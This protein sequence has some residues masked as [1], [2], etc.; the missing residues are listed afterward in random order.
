MGMKASF[1]ARSNGILV[2]LIETF[3]VELY[4]NT[5]LANTLLPRWICEWAARESGF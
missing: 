5:S 4:N 3:I 2:Q 1:H